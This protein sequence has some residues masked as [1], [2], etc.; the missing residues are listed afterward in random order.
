[1]GLGIRIQLPVVGH[2]ISLLRSV[3]SFDTG[4]NNALVSQVLKGCIDIS[5]TRFE[6]LELHFYNAQKL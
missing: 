2:R 1:M 6:V 4:E 5:R 3:K